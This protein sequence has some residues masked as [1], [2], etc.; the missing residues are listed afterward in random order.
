M[1]KVYI[2]RK[3]TKKFQKKDIEA[4]P[5]R[6]DNLANWSRT[7]YQLRHSPNWVKNWRIEAL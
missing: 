2:W 4:D 7:R 3:Y 1:V 6:P 5:S